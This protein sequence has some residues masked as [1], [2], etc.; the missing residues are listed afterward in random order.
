MTMRRPLA[1]LAVTLTTLV[2]ALTLTAGA[3]GAAPISTYGQPAQI[4]GGSSCNG[5]YP[6]NEV[7]CIA[8]AYDVKRQI[9]VGGVVELKYARACNAFFGVVTDSPSYTYLYA[10]ITNQSSGFQ[11]L[12]TF[13]GAVAARLFSRM[14]GWDDRDLIQFRGCVG[15]FASNCANLTYP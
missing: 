1:A 12:D 3:S 5:K 6:Q 13:Q 11:Y 8:S 14:V 7:N 4:C 9:V 15:H 2:A 10:F